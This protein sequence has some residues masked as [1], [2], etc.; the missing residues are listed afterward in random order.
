MLTDLFMTSAC[1]GYNQCR[2]EHYIQ[3][4]HKLEKGRQGG[5]LGCRSHEEQ[6]EGQAS[7]MSYL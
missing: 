3:T 4:K 7:Q 5:G 6:V 2:R 1:F